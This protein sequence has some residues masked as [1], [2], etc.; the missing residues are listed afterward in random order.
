V[1]GRLAPRYLLPSWPPLLL[2]AAFAARALW[3]VPG[4]MRLP[5]RAL[6]LASLAAAAAWGALFAAQLARQPQNAPMAAIDRRQYLETW[7][8]G[9]AIPQIVAAL[10]AE[11]ARQGS[12]V[13]VNHD[14]PRLAHLG[15][16]LYLRH[17][18]QI[19]IRTVDLRATDA[20]Q[21]LQAAGGGRP[22]YLVLDDQEW[23]AFDIAARFPELQL[24]RRYDNPHGAMRF[25]LLALPPK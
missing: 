19:A 25:Y 12:I 6:C 5:A 13:L 9:Y 18:P 1:G 22:I 15:P 2:A 16:T 3:H 17:N 21:Q 20:G 4:R 23:V 14:Q 11:A 8:A 7:T 10:E 24:L